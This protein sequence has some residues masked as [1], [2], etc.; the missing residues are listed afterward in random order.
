MFTIS[1]RNQISEQRDLASLVCFSSS[2]L[3]NIG[4]HTIP[5][6]IPIW[7]SYHLVYSFPLLH[8]SS[9]LPS[10]SLITYLFLSIDRHNYEILVFLERDFPELL[11]FWRFQNP[12]TSSSE[13]P[14]CRRIPSL[15]TAMLLCFFIPVTSLLLTFLYRFLVGNFQKTWKN[16]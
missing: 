14:N 13:S 11:L 1:N 4:R 10:H 12:S 9:N 8:S 15:S 6:L 7:I 3:N 2:F 5:H 16:R